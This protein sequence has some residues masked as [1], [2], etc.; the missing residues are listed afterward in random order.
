VGSD[1]RI[2]LIYR[3]KDPIFE[4]FLLLSERFF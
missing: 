3:S 1:L 2:I 4:L